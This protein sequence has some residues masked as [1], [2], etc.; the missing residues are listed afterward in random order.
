MRLFIAVNFSEDIKNKLEAV[1]KEVKKYTLTGNF[2]FRENL[3][4]TVVF[5]GETREGERVKRILDEL[6]APSFRLEMSGLGSFSR[7]SK[8]IVW[9]GVKKN[10]VLGSA[11]EQLSAALS[12]GGFAIEKRAYK[13]HL[14]L[15]RE[16]AF[17][18]GCAAETLAGLLA[19][20]SLSA[21]V[22]KI[23]LMKSERVGG[24]LV[25]TEIHHA[26]LL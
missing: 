24:K 23:S 3:H 10:A 16:V 14:T 8:N 17:K 26:K 5:I 21:E 2:T 13:P 18:P 1:Q 19:P 6:S 4:L 9:V 25:Y 22:N 12:A 11:Y 7:G 20:V 15:G